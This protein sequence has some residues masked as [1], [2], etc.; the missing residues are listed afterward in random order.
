MKNLI[1]IRTLAV[2]GAI[3]AL[4][5]S[6]QAQFSGKWWTGDTSDNADTIPTGAPTATFTATAINFGVSDSDAFDFNDFLGANGTVTSGSG[7]AL[8]DNSHVELTGQLFLNAGV[9]NFEIGHDDGE[10]LSV[11]GATVTGADQPGPTAFDL[12]DF[13]ITAGTAGTYDFT[14]EYNECCGGPA[15]LEWTD[16]NGTPITAPDAATT[17]TLL[18]AA[19]G[20]LALARRFRK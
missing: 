8:M 5:T 16:M 6:A 11:P 17:A 4:A 13:T 20:G 1:T 7:A 18:G 14:L 15:I 3:A 19:F 10:D 2:A 12:T 9:N